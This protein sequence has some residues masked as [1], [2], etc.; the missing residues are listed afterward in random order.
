L[1]DRELERAHSSIVG[2]VSVAA[3]GIGLIEGAKTQYGGIVRLWE[4]LERDFAQAESGEG[5]EFF[6]RQWPRKLTDR[7][8]GIATHGNEEEMSTG[9][10]KARDFVH[11]IET[12]RCGKRLQRINLQDE[13]EI[14]FPLCRRMENISGD[15][16]DRSPAGSR[17]IGKP[18]LPGTNGGGRNVESGHFKSP[19]SELLGVIAEAAAN[20][21]GT[22]SRGGQG[23]CAPKIKK[24]AIR[25][26]VGPGNHTLPCFSFLVELLEPTSWI[27]LLVEFSSEFASARSV[28]HKSKSNVAIYGR[29]SRGTSREW[30]LGNMVHE[31]PVCEVEIGDRLEEIRIEGYMSGEERRRT[32]RYGFIA[33]AELIEVISDVRIVTRVSELSRFG[34]YLDMM[35]PF[36]VD[37]KVLVKIS[38]GDAYFEGR[39]KIAY[40]QPNMGA[41]VMFMEIEERYVPVLERWLEDMEKD[42]VRR[43]G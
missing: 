23:M 16:F 4:R 26:K 13:I 31:N 9:A 7:I 29:A 28:T 41:G 32:P 20:N 1:P 38:A 5:R 3:R 43:L 24:M 18:L 39:G 12:N 14:V 33:S 25:L 22:F 6:A 42:R 34:C 15:M 36:P 37:T 10:Q 11:G 17:T 35:N 19:A 40:S 2:T 30:Q 21:Q 27:T 8:I